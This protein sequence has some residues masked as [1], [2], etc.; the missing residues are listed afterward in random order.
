MVRWS[1]M[2]YRG[3]VDKIRT[4]LEFAENPA[5]YAKILDIAVHNEWM[6]GNFREARAM[7]EESRKI[8]L[9]LGSAG[10]QGLAEAF[11]LS[12]MIPLQ[13]GDYDEA[14]PFFE[15]SFELYQ[16]CGDKW[17][18]AFARFFLGNVASEKGEY[19]KAFVWMKQS[20][21]LF[22]ELGDPWGMARA[23]QRLGELF[24][25]QGFYEKARLYFEQHLSLDEEL[26]F[27]Q[28]FAVA[29]GN[30]GTL[31]RYQGDYDQAEQYY[32][33]SLAVGREFSIKQEGSFILYNLSMVALQQNNYSIARL[34]FLDY[35][36]VARKIYEKL[37]ACDLLVSFA[38]IAA[39]MGKPERA[40]RLYGA[41]QALFETTDYRI[42][43]FDQ[44]EFDRHIQIARSQLGGATFEEFMA[45]GY[46]MTMEQAIAYALENSDE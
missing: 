2:E 23:T 31:Y 9:Q 21:D 44:A 46:E 35:F 42:P 13:E 18:M 37:S 24:L 32:E 19:D 1:Y 22:R 25:K 40:A 15:Q 43:P 16:R 38:A 14:V 41:V 11:Y 3:W 7:V 10:T 20:L 6:A 45:E 33:K 4:L 5:S 17:G 26:D 8:W 27:N 39:G 30:L 28:G 12:G 29:L 34:R 36:E